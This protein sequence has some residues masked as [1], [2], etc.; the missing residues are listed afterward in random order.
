MA[1]NQGFAL[2]LIVFAAYFIATYWKKILFFLA[3]LSITVFCF[4]IYGIVDTIH[5]DLRPAGAR[6]AE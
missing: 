4:G 6:A 3:V 1:G 5:G 2:I